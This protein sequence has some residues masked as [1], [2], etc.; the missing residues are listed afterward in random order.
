[1]TTELVFL[2]PGLGPLALFIFYFK[3]VLVSLS[4]LGAVIAQPTQ[5]SPGPRGVYSLN[6]DC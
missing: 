5:Y 3:P 4:P 6:I 1:M 2:R